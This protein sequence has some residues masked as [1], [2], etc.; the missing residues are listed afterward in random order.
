MY[1]CCI[2]LNTFFSS[3][4]VFMDSSFSSGFRCLGFILNL[5]IAK[6]GLETWTARKSSNKP[7]SK[8]TKPTTQ[9]P[10]LKR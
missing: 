9:N 2:D 3:M 6:I 10:A 7:Q 5:S 4:E 1:Y 8:K